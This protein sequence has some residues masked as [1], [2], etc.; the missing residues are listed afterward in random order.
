MKELLGNIFV[1]FSGCIHSIDM[2]HIHLG[3][4]NKIKGVDTGYL[5]CAHWT[6]DRVEQGN[7]CSIS[8]FDVATETET[9]AFAFNALQ[10][11]THNDRTDDILLGPVVA[12]HS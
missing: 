10:S 2:V 5:H 9:K 3:H 11:F 6:L 1:F 8:T 7:N 12:E 4:I